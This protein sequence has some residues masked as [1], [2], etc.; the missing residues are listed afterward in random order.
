MRGRRNPM[1]P[2]PFPVQYRSW[3][4]RTQPRTWTARL[5]GRRVHDPHNVSTI[6]PARALSINRSYAPVATVD[7]VGDTG[8][9]L[10]VGIVDVPVFVHIGFSEILAA[11]GF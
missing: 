2:L 10:V 4:M 8:R 7:V 3:N 5:L 1:A 11:N 9:V 6:P